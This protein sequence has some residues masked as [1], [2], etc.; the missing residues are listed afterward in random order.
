MGENYSATY[1]T[2]TVFEGLTGFSNELKNEGRYIHACN[3]W[4]NIL[5]L[6]EASETS[7]NVKIHKGHPYFFLAFYYL[8][9]GYIET[10]FVYA[11]NAIKQDEVLNELC[12]ELNYPQKAPIYLT[13]FLVDNPNNCMIELVRVLR[14]ELKVHIKRYKNEFTR[15][16]TIEDFDKRF[17]Q[18]EDNPSLKGPRYL[19]SYCFWSLIEQKK[20]IKAQITDNEFSKLKNLNWF[21]NLCL[22]VDKILE[23]NPKINRDKISQ[24]VNKVFQLEGF[25]S[26]FDLVKKINKEYRIDF[27]KD[28]PDKVLNILMQMNLLVDSKKVPKLAIHY[29]IAW[30]LRNYG[31]HNI[32]LQK[33]LVDRFDEIFEILMMCIIHSINLL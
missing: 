30:R 9:S 2:T 6:V 32:R 16:F 24:N 33:C 13:T 17:L 25:T 31:G 3:Y 4:R 29:L 5:D 14:Q 7:N 11:S 18:N 27:H 10:G 22:I 1:L 20:K 23:A 8:L 28:D 15:E 19:F 21:F 12:P 26:A